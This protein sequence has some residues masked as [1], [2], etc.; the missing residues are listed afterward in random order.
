MYRI[1]KSFPPLEAISHLNEIR[2][3]SGS[4]LSR[5]VGGFISLKFKLN[6]AGPEL[7]GI[8]VCRYMAAFNL[9]EKN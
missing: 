3:H 4:L 5:V 9:E 6:Y 2:I 8:N 1:L 7:F